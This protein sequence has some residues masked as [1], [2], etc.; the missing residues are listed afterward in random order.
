M[1]H[2]CVCYKYNLEFFLCCCM[3]M[4]QYLC[5]LAWWLIQSFLVD[6]IN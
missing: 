4:L 1:K 6:T 5:E 3:S 2:K